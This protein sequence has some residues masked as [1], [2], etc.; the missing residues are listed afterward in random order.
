MRI[1]EHLL[2]GEKVRQIHCA[3]CSRL[4][5]MADTLVL[6]STDGANALSPKNR[7]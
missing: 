2:M 1:E 5:E 4:L 6:H 3:K 7:E